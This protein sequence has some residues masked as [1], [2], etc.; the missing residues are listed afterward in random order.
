MKIRS[1]LVVEPSANAAM[2][3]SAGADVTVLDLTGSPESWN[4]VTD[5]H[6]GWTDIS[7]HDRLTFLLPAFSS[8]RTNAAVD[9]AVRCA[10][11]SVILP[12]AR[13]GADVQRLDT[14]LRV[15]EI[16]AGLIPGHTAIAALAD[17]AGILAAPSFERCSTRLK[18][19]GWESGHDP[20]SDTARFA[21][22]AIV[23][24]A[25]AA[26]V[27]AIDAVSPTSDA[28][29][30]PSE[31]ETARMNGFSGKLCRSLDQIPIINRIFSS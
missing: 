31:C 29:T 25:S 19:I 27:A 8:A 24:A 11:A 30:F 23:L 3:H 2:V 21:A 7:P 14:M 15:A 22:A 1:W 5:F 9:I 12:G 16:R 13:S 18:F 4:A 10:A 17:A 26:G 6:R 28:A 20:L